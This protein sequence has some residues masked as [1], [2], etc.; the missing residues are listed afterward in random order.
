MQ[1]TG[2]R[3]PCVTHSVS[4]AIGILRCFA[5]MD[6]LRSR[7][8]TQRKAHCSAYMPPAHTNTRLTRPRPHAQLYG[9]APQAPWGMDSRARSGHMSYT[10]GSDRALRW[11]CT[12]PCGRTMWSRPGFA[13][14][15]RVAAAGGGQAVL[16]Q[17]LRT[18]E[19]IAH[20][21]VV[22]GGWTWQFVHDCFGRAHVH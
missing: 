2:T 16:W 18:P 10:D 9:P 6:L 14:K 13:S 1:Y 12:A 8:S 3:R 5:V 4:V 21:A 19:S 20:W 22:S 7:C 17:P 15:L 11:Q